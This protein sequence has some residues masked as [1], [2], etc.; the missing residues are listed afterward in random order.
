MGEGGASVCSPGVSLQ[1]EQNGEWP[2]TDVES[3]AGSADNSCITDISVGSSVAATPERDPAVAAE[4]E[5]VT[6]ADASSTGVVYDEAMELHRIQRGSVPCTH[7]CEHKSTEN[8]ILFLLLFFFFF[9]GSS[10]P[11]RPDRIKKIFATLKK[12]G[13]LSR[14]RML[15]V[16]PAGDGVAAA[17]FTCFFPLFFLVCRAAQRPTARLRHA[18]RECPVPPNPLVSLS[19]CSFWPVFRKAHR[20]K[21]DSLAIDYTDKD[22]ERLGNAYDSI[23]LNKVNKKKRRRKKKKTNNKKQQIASSIWFVRFP[24]SFSSST[25]FFLFRFFTPLLSLSPGGRLRVGHQHTSAAARLSAGCLIELT[26]AVCEDRVRNGV[27]VIRPPGHHAEHVRRK[28]IP[29]FVNPPPPTK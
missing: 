4:A 22:L 15:P 19:S 11:E 13:L 6:F 16:S 28:I 10:H 17:P 2:P 5:A 7:A 14:C 20:E 18:T 23:Y 21:M 9:F 1:Q 25:F 8:L 27:A 26:Q 3:V 12:L 29:S 24:P